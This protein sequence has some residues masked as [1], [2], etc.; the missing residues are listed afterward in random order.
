M[1]GGI[2]T[3]LVSTRRPLDSAA[4]D[5]IRAAARAAMAPYVPLA[6]YTRVVFLRRDGE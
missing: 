5:E 1:R 2:A 3:V 6:A 4:Q